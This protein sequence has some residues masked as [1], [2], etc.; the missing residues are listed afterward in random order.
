MCIHLLVAGQTSQIGGIVF[1]FC[2]LKNAMNIHVYAQYIY[3]SVVGGGITSTWNYECPASGCSVPLGIENGLIED[4]RITA[5]ST[6]SSWYSGPWK[7]FLARLNRQGTINAWQAKVQSLLV[8][9]Q[10]NVHA[11]KLR[12]K[13][14]KKMWIQ[15]L[16]VLSL[17]R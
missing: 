8:T 6:A 7:P 14:L 1:I 13:T 17:V 3:L 9:W 12:K 4:H 10:V 11:F 15:E 5:S 2:D 16:T